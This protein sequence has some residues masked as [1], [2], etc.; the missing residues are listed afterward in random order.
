MADRRRGSRALT[1]SALSFFSPVRSSWLA[2]VRI[3]GFEAR[4]GAAAMAFLAPGRRGGGSVL[5]DA[6][7]GVVFA[8]SRA[9]R[10]YAI[11]AATGELRWSVLVS[12]APA[13]TVFQPIVD[14]DIVVAGYT[15]F[16]AQQ[17]GGVAAM[18]RAS[19]RVK[20]TRAFDG[21]D[22]PSGFA[23]G[24]VV[25]RARSCWWRVVTDESGAVA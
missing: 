6:A 7:D 21:D 10:V 13:T 17:T 20:W 2:T 25:L 3:H 24:P 14:A 8:G 16:A 19:G 11:D 4:S 23:G 5:G 18:E 22:G 15:T 1:R 9:G 12:S